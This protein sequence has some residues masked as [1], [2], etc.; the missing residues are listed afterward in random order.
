[1]RA[2]PV[3][4]GFK[5]TGLVPWV[6]G[7]GF[8][9][10]F[11]IGATLP[12][13]QAVF[14]VVPF[15]EQPGIEVS[16]VMRLAA[17]E[18]PQT[19]SLKLDNWLLSSEKVAFTKPERWIHTNDQIN[20]TLQGFFALGCARGGLDV[21]LGAFE[22]RGAQ[23]IQ[24]AWIALDRELTACRDAMIEAQRLGGDETTADKLR[25]RAWAIDLAARCAHA[26]VTASSGAANDIR[27]PAQRLY[28]EA[29]VY[30]VSAQTTPIMDAT[31]ARLAG[32]DFNRE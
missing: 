4:S 6:T 32:R 10:E 31:L 9:P 18:S 23:F 14:G 26:A 13:G 15:S 25:L 16:P 3:E 28:R 5:L 2:V 12:D 19:V 22:K 27:H 11:L 21:V 29:L 1:M 17:M 7:L 30:T 8:F 20:I 24:T